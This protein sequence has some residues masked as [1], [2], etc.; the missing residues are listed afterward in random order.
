MTASPLDVI[1][2]PR[3]EG[4]ELTTAIRN[5][6]RGAEAPSFWSQIANSDRY[7][8]DHRRRAVFALFARH[9][10]PGLSLGELAGLLDNPTWVRDEDITAITR[11]GGKLPVRWSVN[12]TVFLFNVFPN[13]PDGIYQSWAIYL[14]VAGKVDRDVF[15]ALIRGR[16]SDSAGQAKILEIGY[17]PPNPFQTGG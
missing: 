8:A 12:D 1:A 16:P 4:A 14:K 15:V 17:A 13:V 10:S 2:N 5:L 6:P 3:I 7:S 9:I 11:L